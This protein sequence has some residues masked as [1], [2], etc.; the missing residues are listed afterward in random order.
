MKVH[1]VVSLDITPDEPIDGTVIGTFHNRANAIKECAD[2][3]IERLYLRADIRYAFMHDEN[4][5]EL[6]GNLSDKAGIPFSEVEEMFSYDVND[7]EWNMPPEVE[8]FIKEWLVDE[9]RAGGYY[10]IEV[11]GLD[12][13]I[14]SHEFVFKVIENQLKDES[15][16]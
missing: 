4:H 11:Y 2:Y 5:P 1:S 7:D 15:N 6:E 14:G 8:S 12:E 9:I 16:G 13:V 10:E 3:I